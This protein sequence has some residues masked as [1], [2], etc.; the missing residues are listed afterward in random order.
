MRR[1][2]TRND[3]ILNQVQDDKYNLYSQIRPSMKIVIATGIF[4]PD[5]GGPATYVKNIAEKFSEMGHKISVVSYADRN[6]PPLS[7]PEEWAFIF[8]G[9]NLFLRYFKYFWQ[10]RKFSRGADLVYAQGPL[11]AGLPAALACLLGGKRLVLKIVGDTA[12]ERARS[13]GVVR[14]EIDEFQNGKYGFKTELL[15]KIQKWV[16]GRAEKIIVPSVYLKKIA[17]GWGVEEKKIRVIYNAFNKDSCQPS[18]LRV[19]RGLGSNQEKTILSVGRLVPWKGFERLLELMTEMPEGITLKIAGDGPEEKRLKDLAEKLKL[20][21]KAEFLGKLPH[22]ELLGV[23]RK[24]DVFVLNTKYEG[25]PHIVL[26]AMAEGLPVVTTNVG[27][28]PEVVENE[29]NGILV[30]PDDK[31]QIK[32]A[33][34]K[35]L[36]NDDFRE[37]IAGQA[38]KAL[39]KFSEEKM[40]K[41][42]L[43]VLAE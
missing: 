21:E 24:S 38:R 14:E 28:N 31:K 22:N 10:V 13:L 20:G 41:K 17:V 43:A 35:I 32:E 15:R 23:M 37:K 6:T 25:L 16:C 3:E 29:I 30:E 8:R 27:G 19:L 33:V 9:Q 11:S 34:L 5:I 26:E 40:I 12:W 1:V 39:G 4:P 7:C 18:P 2:K 42:T 36:R